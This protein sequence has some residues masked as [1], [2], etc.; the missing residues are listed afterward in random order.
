MVDSYRMY[1]TLTALRHIRRF[2]QH[3]TA[4]PES[5]AEHCYFTALLAGAFAAELNAVRPGL[6]DRAEVIEMA[7]WHDAEEALLGDVPHPVLR[8]YPDI[9][10]AWSSVA[11]R[12][13]NQLRALGGPPVLSCDGDTLEALLVKLADW[14]ELICYVREE[15]QAGNRCIDRSAD[16]IWQRLHDQLRVR[17]AAYGPG[18]RDWYDL[19]LRTFKTA[20]GEPYHMSAAD[21][22]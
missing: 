10:E 4:A 13:R 22:P 11:D 14:L 19:T 17:F 8:T 15:Q 6:V 2:Q 20:L 21:A 16:V 9:K 3:H 7:L 5:V 1:R 18:I 12:L